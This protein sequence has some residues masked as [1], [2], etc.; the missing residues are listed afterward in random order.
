MTTNQTIDPRLKIEWQSD[1]NL[2]A[3]FLGDFELFV[4]YRR[5]DDG[6]K[7]K[8]APRCVGKEQVKI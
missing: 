3:E 6:I 7:I 1:S 2:R 5:E 8:F 4:A